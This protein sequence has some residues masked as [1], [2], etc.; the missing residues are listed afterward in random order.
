MDDVKELCLITSC[1]VV[2]FPGWRLRGADS[3]GGKISELDCNTWTRVCTSTVMTRSTLALLA[4]NKRYSGF[5]KV[6][7]DEFYPEVTFY[8]IIVS[9]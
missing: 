5:P 6:L 3:C 2:F 8:L 4:G 7:I 1:D 9:S